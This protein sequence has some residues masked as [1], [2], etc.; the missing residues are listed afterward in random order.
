METRR[1]LS[2][3]GRP[4]NEVVAG[5]IRADII[6]GRFAPGDRLAEERLAKQYSMSRN[7]IREAIRRLESEGF[8]EVLPNRGATVSRM[9]VER[10]RELLQVRSALETLVVRLAATERTD[11]QLAALDRIVSDGQAAV[12]DGRYEDLADLNSQ[13]HALL[14]DASTNHTLTTII[15]Q[16]QDKIAWVYVSKLDARAEDSWAEHEAMLDAI[17]ARDAELAVGL[18]AGHIANAEAAYEVRH[19]D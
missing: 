16:L 17:R 12:A 2:E 1:R 18:M 9:T 3:D 5:L 11:A 7:P 4:L 10:A 15:S 19:P 13:F 6:T 14:A 8:V